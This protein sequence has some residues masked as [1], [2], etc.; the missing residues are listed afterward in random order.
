MK[1]TPKQEKV[2]LFIYYYFNFVD[3]ITI[4]EVPDY[5]G[6]IY[7][8]EDGSFEIKSQNYYIKQKPIPFL[9][10]IWLII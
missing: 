2:N 5:A 9:L 7:I 3:L 6:L 1:I 4:D 8:D 10:G